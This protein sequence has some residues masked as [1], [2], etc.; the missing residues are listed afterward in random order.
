MH[1][2]SDSSSAIKLCAKRCTGKLRHVEV[3]KFWLQQQLRDGLI[4][5]S[6]LGTH[7]NVSDIFTKPLARNRFAELCRMIG[8]RAG[9]QTKYLA[10]LPPA[11]H[12]INMIYFGE[13]SD[14]EDELTTLSMEASEQVARPLRENWKHI[15]FM[16]WACV[17]GTYGTIAFICHMQQCARKMLVMIGTCV[18]RWS[19][20]SPAARPA[21]V[22]PQPDHR[23]ARGLA[24]TPFRMGGLTP[25][26]C[27]C[28]LQLHVRFVKRGKN[29]G[30]PYVA[31]DRDLADPGRCGYFKWL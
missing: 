27:E 7:T 20:P 22:H 3:R 6:H 21:L 31:C 4:S 23:P 14:V 30:K 8:L 24:L 18:K 2:F 16:I 10:L 9:P 19:R 1:L 12:G 28:G 29:V 25:Y 17:F 5:V 15:A 26:C 13:A 11:E